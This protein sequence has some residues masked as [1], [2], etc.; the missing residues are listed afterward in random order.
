MACCLSG[1]LIGMVSF[2]QSYKN[3]HQ[4]YKPFLLY[5]FH[6]IKLY[7]FDVVIKL[8]GWFL[9]KPEYDLKFY[10]RAHRLAAGRKQVQAAKS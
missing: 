5:H 2:H 10:S 1:I 4:S 9:G 7:L 6:C 8:S 3:F